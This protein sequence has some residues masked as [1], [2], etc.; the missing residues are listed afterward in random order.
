MSVQSG[1]QTK[2]SC[3]QFGRPQSRREV[4]A[5]FQKSENEAKNTNKLTSAHSVRDYNAVVSGAPGSVQGMR[6]CIFNSKFF[7]LRAGDNSVLFLFLFINYLKY[8]PC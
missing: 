5:S 8:Y 3:T 6:K 2:S 1:A 7:N 4:L